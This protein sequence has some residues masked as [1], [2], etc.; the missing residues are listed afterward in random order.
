MSKSDF[1]S[2][3]SAMDVDGDGEVN[4]MEF[5]AFMTSCGSAYNK[6]GKNFDKL[7]KKEQAEEVAK[8]IDD[9]K[10]S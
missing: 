8:L 7:S 10:V 2:L 9:K 6:A 4:F 1:E 5:C 3:F